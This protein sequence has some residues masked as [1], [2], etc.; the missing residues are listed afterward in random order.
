MLLLV[1]AEAVAQSSLR[2]QAPPWI[3]CG[4]AGFYPAALNLKEA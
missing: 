1:C 4:G 3:V 2:D